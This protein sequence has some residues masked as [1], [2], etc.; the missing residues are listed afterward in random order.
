MAKINRSAMIVC[1]FLVG[2][3]LCAQDASQTNSLP[4]TAPG[5]QFPWPQFQGP[6]NLA[7][8]ID[9][10]ARAERRF[11][12]LRRV[13]VESLRRLADTDIVSVVVYNDHASVLVP[14]QEAKNRAEIME[15]IQEL[16]PRGD[17]ALFA[18]ISAAAEEL[19]K[20][21]DGKFTNRIFVLNASLG[22]VGPHSEGE[23]WDFADALAKENMRV[24]FAGM[25]RRGRPGGE[26][27][28]GGFRGRGRPGGFGVRGF[29]P[30]RMRIPRRQSEVR[31]GEKQPQKER[32]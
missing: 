5:P 7:I 32:P 10:S 17:A 9:C 18:G 27:R 11:E 26:G 20:N 30:N 23:M 28:S 12:F 14:A 29:G 22:N 31:E 8:V 1:A 24:F 21:K 16:K 2:T 13:A 4:Q 3:A 15:N 6:Q 19:R 25:M